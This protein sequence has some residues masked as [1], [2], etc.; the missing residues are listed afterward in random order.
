M[1]AKPPAPEPLTAD[2]KVQ[3]TSTSDLP[4]PTPVKKP[5]AVVKPSTTR[6]GFT[7]VE[8][9]DSPYSS[10]PQVIPVEGASYGLGIRHIEE[11][12]DIVFERWTI[13]SEHDIFRF[14]IGDLVLEEDTVKADE[15]T[16]ARFSLNIPRSKVPLGFVND[17]YGEVERVGSTQLSTSPRQVVFIKDTR[18]GGGRRPS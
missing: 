4:R 13:L 9:L 7:V 15:V 3:A 10:P 1:P 11:G 6:P 18:P 2:P 16:N 12:L 5:P 8:D 17:V 14:K